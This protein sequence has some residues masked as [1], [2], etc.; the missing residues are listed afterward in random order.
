MIDACARAGRQPDCVMATVGHALEDAAEFANPN[1]VKL[2]MDAAGRALFFAHRSR[3]GA[4][5]RALPRGALRHVGLYAYRAGFLRR[6]RS[7]PQARWNR[8]NRWSSCACSG[9]AAH[10]RARQRRSPARASIRLR[11]SRACAL[12]LQAPVRAGQDTP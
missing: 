2:V 6:F 11:T 9:M 5:A 4:T 1:V 8:P 3:G 10:R 12:L 7:W